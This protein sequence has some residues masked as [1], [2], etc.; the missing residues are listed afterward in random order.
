MVDAEAI[1]EAV[2]C[3]NVRFI[4]IKTD[5]QLELR[6]CTGIST[7]SF[8]GARQSLTRYEHFSWSAA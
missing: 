1:A 5:D 8:H 4:P 2:E 3:K 7:G 6:R